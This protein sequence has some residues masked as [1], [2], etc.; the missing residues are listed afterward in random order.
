MAH[1]RTPGNQ[2]AHMLRDLDDG[3]R[4]RHPQLL[5]SSTSSA[6]S[7]ARTSN[8]RLLPDDDRYLVD[9]EDGDHFEVH[10]GT[11][12]RSRQPLLTARRRRNLG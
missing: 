9:R 8:G 11:D 3:A 10:G 2:G 6:D 1:R 5:A 4:D 12:A 7:P